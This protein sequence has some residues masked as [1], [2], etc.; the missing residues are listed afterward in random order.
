VDRTANR[1]DL[2]P[3]RHQLAVLLPERFRGGCSFGAGI[4]QTMLPTSSASLDWQSNQD[5]ARSR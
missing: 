5:T 2:F 1:L 3:E 4:M